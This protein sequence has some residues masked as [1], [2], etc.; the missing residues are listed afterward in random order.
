MNTG[1]NF[2]AYSTLLVGGY[3]YQD[4]GTRATKKP[5]LQSGLTTTCSGWNV[6][7]WNS[8][9]LTGDGT[10]GRRG[11]GDE[12]D[13]TI[14][15]GGKVETALGPFT[16]SIGGAYYALAHNKAGLFSMPD[17]VGYLYGEVGRP[18]TV[19]VPWSEKAATLTPTFRLADYLYLAGGHDI[20]LRY[21]VAFI[22]PLP[23]NRF[24]VEG[25]VT[26][27]TKITHGT[28]TVFRPTIFGVLDLGHGWNVL[29]G[30]ECAGQVGCAE[31]LKLRIS[32]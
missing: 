23:W 7:L 16:Y 11:G 21:G 29:A 9:Q 4:F 28:S 1:C 20:M 8:S 30:V 24:S 26:A 15:Y 12:F 13:I 17:D 25:D 5:V 3:L 27:A 32:F 10:Y 14:W 18:F 2:N 31:M 6:D 19:S 22:V